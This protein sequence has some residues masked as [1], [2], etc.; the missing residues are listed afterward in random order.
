MPMKVE[1]AVITQKGLNAE[2]NCDSVNI[3]GK[4]L[5]REVILNG[6]KGAGVMSDS[7][8]FALSH[9]DIEGFADAAVAAFNDRASGFVQSNAAPEII[10]GFFED[11]ISALKE[12]D[13]KSS[14][15]VCSVLYA[16]GRSVIIG[17]TGETSV[18][19]YSQGTLSR[20][21]PEKKLYDDGLASYGLN[22]FNNVV[23]DDLFI[24][25]SPGLSE[26]LTDKDIADI[27]RISDG[28]VKKI[29]NLVNKVSQ[30]K[31][32]ELSSTVIAVRI[33]ET[34]LIPVNNV[35]GFAAFFEKE[36]DA[37][38][39]E[40][41]DSSIE[42][43][44]AEPSVAEVSEIPSEPE[45]EENIVTHEEPSKLSS[46]IID[47]D[48]ST[49]DPEFDN[50]LLKSDDTLAW[51]EDNKDGNSSGKNKTVIGI[52]AAVVIVLLLAAVAV[53]GKFFGNKAPEEPD[54]TVNT[55]VEIT[56]E[57]ETTEEESTT[58][59]ETT[60][61]EESTTEQ[62]TSSSYWYAA[63]NTTFPTSA[64]TAPATTSAPTTAAPTT[65]AP[66]T[67][68][69]ISSSEPTSDE[70]S[71]APTEYEPSSEEEPSVSEDAPSA[72]EA[73]VS[74]FTE[75]NEPSVDYPVAETDEN[76]EP[77]FG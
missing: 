66:T 58:D 64:P 61:E 21:E 27:C 4:V 50:V 36:A 15:L 48:D 13:K 57:A 31:N 18:Y 53:A 23:V 74:D 67:E 12:M 46:L 71:Q 60:T 28:S 63:G 70:A 32:N 76:Q 69:V 22:L 59:T 44:A 65:A 41:N 38:D 55:T 20:I 45:K 68:P 33:L 62:P 54:E 11:S 56:T 16:C 75:D 8:F 24:L 52:V 5:P 49:A 7:V 42:E 35:E 14:D 39:D 3:N 9:S 1:A 73:P 77:L 30:A 17:K 34:E 2:F 72:T 25:L 10:S 26:V 40:R 6:Y 19:N 47:D 29:V 43:K 37:A 51:L